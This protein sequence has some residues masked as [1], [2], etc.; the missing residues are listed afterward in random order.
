MQ[1]LSYEQSVEAVSFRRE[2]RRGALG[3]KTA[4]NSGRFSVFLPSVAAKT[5]VCRKKREAAR[6]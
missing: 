5:E 3:L 2:R 6:C 4:E 1:I